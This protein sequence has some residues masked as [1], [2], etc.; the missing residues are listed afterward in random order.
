M[1]KLWCKFNQILSVFIG[2]ISIIKKGRQIL[3]YTIITL[4]TV[5]I[6]YVWNLSL[7]ELVFLAVPEDGTG[8]S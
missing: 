3:R 6:W 4:P 1:L 2:D 7:H 8:D 5:W